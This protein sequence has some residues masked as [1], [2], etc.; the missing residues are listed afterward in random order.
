MGNDTHKGA[1]PGGTAKDS[2]VGRGGKRYVLNVMAE[3]RPGIVSAVSGAVADLGGNIEAVSQTVLKGYFTLIMIVSMPPGVS[4]EQLER[5]VGATGGERA[6][7]VLVRPV[8]PFPPPAVPRGSESFVITVMGEDR[9]G[10]IFRVSSYLAEKGVNITDLYGDRQ[11][12]RFVLV[13]QVQ[14]P[15]QWDIAMLQADLEHMGEQLGFTVR[16]QH[17][18]VFVATNELRLR[19]EASP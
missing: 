7:M 4:G 13:S 17:E 2:E 15:P 19:R 14:V 5:T 10:T 12:N 16:M 18:N 8:V 3:D 1:A 11:Q 9:P 6:F